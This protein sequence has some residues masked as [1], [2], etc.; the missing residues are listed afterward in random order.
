M[1]DFSDPLYARVHALA[2]GLLE[3]TLAAEERAELESLIF[4]N[5]APRKAYLY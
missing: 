4:N 1:N 2:V 3:G 5:P